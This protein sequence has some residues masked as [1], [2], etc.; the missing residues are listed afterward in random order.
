MTDENIA[1]GTV[2][3][4]DGNRAAAY[5]VLVSNPNVV[6]LYPITPQTS[7][8][9]YLASFKANGLL[10]AEIVEVEGEIS[11]MGVAIGAALA[12]GRS[13][14]ASSSMGLYFMFDTYTMAPLARTPV[15]MV[16]ANRENSPAAVAAGQQDIMSVAEAG[17]I[18]IHTESCQ[19]IL[20]SIIMAYRLA[21]DP[22]ILLPV[23]VCYDGFYLS[24]LAMPVEIPPQETVNRFLPR[25]PRP[26]LG[27]DPLMSGAA[28]MVPAEAT[29][30]RYRHQQA[31]ERVKQ[32]IEKIDYEFARIFGRCYGGLIDEYR[33]EDAEYALITLGSHTG[34][35]RVAVDKK[36]EEGFPVGLV[37]IRVHRPFPWE[38]LAQAL[39]GKRAVGVIDRSVC[40]GWNC[41]HL[42]HELQATLQRAAL[43]IPSID[44]IDGLA[45]GDISDTHIE[46]VIELTH[47]ASLGRPVKRLSWLPLEKV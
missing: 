12:G 29:E 39:K 15:V 23:I 40:L 37:K 36:R 30:A 25:T 21:E 16:N 8:I 2:K 45:G 4:C 28:T 1:K 47:E 6:A 32:R 22:D 9:E 19:E 38:R 44:F 14:T 24:Y 20:D 3:V 42:Y 5:G 18:Q 27:L 41:G 35:A 17:W 46:R 11:A 7:L 13:F 34:T 33:M 43:D 10:S 31:L 26:H